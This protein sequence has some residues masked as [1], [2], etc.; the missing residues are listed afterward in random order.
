MALLVKKS[1][2]KNE[3]TLLAFLDFRRHVELGRTRIDKF[4]KKMTKTTS[5][6]GL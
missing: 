6:V 4:E 2:L 1:R 3:G 5:T